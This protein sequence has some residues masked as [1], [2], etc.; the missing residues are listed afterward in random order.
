LKSTDTWQ[1]W[2]SFRGEETGI[3]VMEFA[4]RT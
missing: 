3:E 4:H 1:G 2:I